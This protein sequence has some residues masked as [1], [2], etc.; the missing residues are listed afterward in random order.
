MVAQKKNPVWSSNGV[1]W[2]GSEVASS[3]EEARVMKDTPE[4][5]SPVSRRRVR[6]IECEVDHRWAVFH[7][8]VTKRMLDFL[9]N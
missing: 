8:A 9:D 6:A 5:T 3:E 7:Q 2:A 4:K 1:E